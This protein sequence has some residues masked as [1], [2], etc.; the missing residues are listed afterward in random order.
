MRLRRSGSGRR[1]CPPPEPSRKTRQY[2]GGT[3]RRR[4]SLPRGA[5]GDES[6]PDEVA[7]VAV[8]AGGDV[9]H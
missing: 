5:R 8:V 3:R 7:R 6:R 1:R 9:P 2:P 4:S